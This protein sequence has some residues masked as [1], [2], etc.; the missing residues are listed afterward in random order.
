MA[1]WD[2]PADTPDLSGVSLRA[3]ALNRSTGDLV[4][5]YEGKDFRVCRDQAQQQSKSGR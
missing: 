1:Y 3:M 4:L 5:A 2:P